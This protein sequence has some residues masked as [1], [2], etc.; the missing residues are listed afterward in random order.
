MIPCIHTSTKCS[1]CK[2]A[3]PY[4]VNG[5]ESMAVLRSSMTGDIF[6]WV[7]SILS[8]SA[9]VPSSA[10]SLKCSHL[11]A[12]KPG[13]QISSWLG[14]LTGIHIYQRDFI[15][16]FVWIFL[17]LIAHKHHLTKSPLLH[18]NKNFILSFNL[19]LRKG[20][21]LVHSQH[22][23]LRTSSVLFNPH[24]I[25]LYPKQVALGITASFCII[26]SCTSPQ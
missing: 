19:S 2:M 7:W 16:V 4:A 12:P 9:S 26:P 22:M 25:K 21:I 8:W 3:R 13:R 5:S 20:D 6:L 18:T 1:P 15:K 17:R 10:E 11:T 14:S 23:K 24:H